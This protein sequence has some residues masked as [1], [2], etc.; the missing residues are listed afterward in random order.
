MEKSLPANMVGKHITIDAY[1]ISA[2]KLN[3]YK[4]IFTLL[5]QLPGKIGMR[6]LTTPHLVM[7]DNGK[8]NVGISG[9]VMLYESHVSCHTW[10]RV[11]YISMDV[12]SCKDF[13][14]KKLL[15]ELKHYWGWKKVETEVVKRGK[16]NTKPLI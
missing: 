14:E 7:C 6:K 4:Y 2:K 15:R 8:N 10:P 1:G 12:Y 5:D 3:D 9:F 13:D 16:S 11:G